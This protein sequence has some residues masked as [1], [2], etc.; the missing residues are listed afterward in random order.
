MAETTRI[1]L[2]LSA[3]LAETLREAVASGDYANRAE[4]LRDALRQWRDKRS[5]VQIATP[6]RTRGKEIWIK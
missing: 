3:D 1:S 5:Q 6:L 4:I 2:T